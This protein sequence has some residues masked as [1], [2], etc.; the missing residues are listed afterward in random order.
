MLAHEIMH[1]VMVL[2]RTPRTTY[3]AW[4]DA[5]GHR[6]VYNMFCNHP[7]RH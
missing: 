5:P 3:V 6:L 1:T 4:A 7:M 2:S